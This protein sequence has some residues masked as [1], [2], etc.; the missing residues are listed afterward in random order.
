[1][2]IAHA[3]L[4]WRALPSAARHPALTARVVLETI[5]QVPLRSG[6]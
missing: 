4:F 3:L 1:M 5:W 6:S 2:N